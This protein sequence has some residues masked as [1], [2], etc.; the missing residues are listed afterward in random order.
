MDNEVNARVM[1][2][3]EQEEYWHGMI[4]VLTPIVKSYCSDMGMMV[5]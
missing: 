4:Q 3:A 1:G 5:L 2:N